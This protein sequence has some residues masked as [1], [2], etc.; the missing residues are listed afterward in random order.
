MVDDAELVTRA[1][2]GDRDAFETLVARHSD[3]AARAAGRM[4][5]GPDTDDVVQEAFV[6][7]YRRL[8]DY[9]GESSFRSWLLAIVANETR[10]LHR[11]RRRRDEAGA[12]AAL[13][14]PAPDETDAPV[15]STLAAEDRR[16]IV[17]A[18]AGLDDA[19]RDVIAYRY[20]LDRSEA[21]TAALL[22]LPVG[23]VKSRT[24]RA[25]AK[26]RTRLGVAIA[27]VVAALV[28]IAVPPARTAVADV[29]S[30]V[31]RFAGVEVRHGSG[32]PV[33]IPVS[34]SPLPSTRAVTLDEARRLARFPVGMPTGLGTP[35]AVYVSDPDGDGAP[36]VVSLL[37]RGGA[38]R[39]DEYDGQ[40]DLT[41]SKTA[42]D[43]TWM[44]VGAQPAL[45]LAKPHPVTY[46]DRTG[47]SWPAT[48]RL[49]GPTLLW[50]VGDVGYRIEG[51]ATSAEAVE[52]AASINF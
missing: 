26:L 44:Q 12:R 32:A 43:V 40:F 18:V 19:D 23:T 21:E 2:G 24:S 37:F 31:L 8:P 10:N 4:G 15:A 30:H 42:G 16:Q 29:I 33:I 28:I 47:V 34:P 48:T 52:V 36:R 6:R 22:D 9:R 39:I 17:A 46:V 51:L 27:V 20:L 45:W 1:R 5:A 50:Q 14:T 35:F 38:V 25:M 7:A 13:A 49:A 3:A 11:S 41:F